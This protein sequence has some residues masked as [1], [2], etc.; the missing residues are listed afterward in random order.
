MVQKYNKIRLLILFVVAICGFYP[1]SIVAQQNFTVVLD[2]GHGGKDPGAI[3]KKIK[4]KDINLEIVL[5]LG[6]LIKKNHPDV[7][8]VYTRSNDI[9]VELSERAKIANKNK[10]DLFISVHTNAAQSKT[11]K[12]TETYALGLAKTEE[13]LEVA[14]RENSVILL[15]DDYSTKYEGFDPTSAES[16]IMF[17]FMQSMYLEQ[18]INLASSVQEQFR[19]KAKRSDRGVRQGAFWVLRATSMPSILIEVGYISN[20][21]EENYLALSSSR[22]KLAESIYDAFSHYKADWSRK[23][24]GNI[25][26]SSVQDDNVVDAT[27]NTVHKEDSKIV[28]EE[29]K[30][31]KEV[32]DYR[33]QI[34]ASDKIYKSSSSVFKGLSNIRYYKENNLYKYT[35]GSFKTKDEAVKQLPKIQQL[36]KGAF[37]V[38]F[39]GDK[40]QLK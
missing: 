9:F 11:A 7:K 2:A 17:D 29:P 25:S 36:F 18:S 22:Q 3:G 30:I 20:A 27:P 39:I 13:N 6:D 26:T 12:G 23:Q 15:E 40:K 37:V 31:V 4:E 10:A 5:K 8:V 1:I 33:I 38:H 35:Y 21:E 28:K 14:K 16:Y 34:M 32:E 24:S 19:T